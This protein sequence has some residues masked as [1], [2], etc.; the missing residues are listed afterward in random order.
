MG[1]Q[2][3]QRKPLLDQRDPHHLGASIRNVPPRA[4]CALPITPI[5]FLGRPHLHVPRILPARLRTVELWN[6]GSRSSIHT[7][8][9]RL[10]PS[11]VLLL[12]FLRPA[13]Q[14]PCKGPERSP[15]RS[16]PILASIPCTS[17]NHRTLR[18]CL[19]QLRARLSRPLDRPYD[20][21]NAH[22]HCQLRNLHGHHRLHDRRLWALLRLRNRR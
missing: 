13:Q 21:F 16:P 10:L 17:R 3:A 15:T 12:P 6:H 19:D 7:C 8:P 1:P 11:L 5:R 18:I 14:D 4:Y 20:L 9:N 2:R 22:R